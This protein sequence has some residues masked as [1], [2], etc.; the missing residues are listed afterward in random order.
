MSEGEVYGDFA[1]R[2]RH[3]IA[4]IARQR[5]ELA[6][7]YRNL[8][9]PLQYTETGLRSFAFM[10]QNSWIFIAVPA[11]LKVASLLF[12]LRAGKPTQPLFRQRQKQE[13][14]PKGFMG[15]ALKWGGHGWKLFKIYRRV[16]RFFP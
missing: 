1:E 7:A 16:R 15:H 5:G 12:A 10:R 3:L 11:A 4:D 8:Q 14:P 2:R 13:T 6:E 9:K